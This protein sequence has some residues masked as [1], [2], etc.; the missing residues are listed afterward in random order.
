[1]GPPGTPAVGQKPTQ[2]GRRQVLLLDTGGSAL[3][4]L[5]ACGRRAPR[6]GTVQDGLGHLHTDATAPYTK[7]RIQARR[8][9]IRG[10]SHRASGQPGWLQDWGRARGAAA[11]AGHQVVWLPACLREEGQIRRHAGRSIALGGGTVEG[12]QPIA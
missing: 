5:A 6:R 12:V 4:A 8:K 9:E 2:N 11:Q 3:A 10:G 7:T 1:M